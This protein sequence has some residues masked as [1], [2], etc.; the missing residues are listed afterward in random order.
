M[1]NLKKLI[2]VII[3]VMMLV[4]SFATVAAADYADVESTNSYYKAIQVLSGL[5][6]AKGDEAGNFNPK[7]DVKRSEMVAFVCRL[8]GEE[9]IAAGSAS[10]A[11]SDVAVSHWATGYIAWGVN[12]GIIN[13]MGDGTFAPDASVTYQDAV[14]M[15]MRA[16]GYD[17]IA[18]RAEN[19]GYPTGYL[20][21]ASQGKVLQNA[22]YDQTKA[23]TREIIAQLI[24]NALTS[25]LVDVYQYGDTFEDDRYVIYNGKTSSYGLRTLLTYTNEMIKINATVKKTPANTPSLITKNGHMVE[26]SVDNT[27]DEKVTTIEKMIWG[28]E[29][30]SIADFKAYVGE[31]DIADCMGETVE[32]YLGFDEDLNDWVVLAAVTSKSTVTETVSENIVGVVADSSDFIL[33]YKENVTDS[34][35]D[36]EEIDIAGTAEVYVNGV[37]VNTASTIG[38]ATLNTTATG[39]SSIT[40]MKNKADA[41]YTRVF[42]TVYTYK[43]VEEVFAEKGRIKY[44]TPGSLNLDP[45]VRNNDDFFYNIYDADGKAIT[46]A[47]V[48]EGDVLNILVPYGYTLAGNTTPSLDIY[49]TSNTVTGT[50][51]EDAGDSKHYTVAG[52]DYTSTSA[53][54]LGEAGVF[55]ISIDGKIVYTDTSVEINKNFAYISYVEA[56]T[57]MGKSTYTMDLLTLD[58]SFVTYTLATSVRI[59]EGNETTAPAV[60]D[61]ALATDMAY[62]INLCKKSAV[63]DTAAITAASTSAEI[64]KRLITFK[65]DAEGKINEIR[66]MGATAGTDPIAKYASPASY[67]WDATFNEYNGL[68]ADEAKIFVVP[69]AAFKATAITPGVEYAVT[70]DDEQVEVASFTDLGDEDAFTATLYQT[71]ED[72]DD[73]VISVALAPLAPTDNYKTAPMAV[74]K[75]VATALD[76]DEQTVESITFVQS[77]EV[78]TIKAKFGLATGLASGDIFQYK[79]NS[80]GELSEV[81]MVVDMSSAI[82]LDATV[83]AYTVDGVG[84][85]KYGFALGYI[86]DLDS[87]IK[88]A[89][90][91]TDDGT[92]ITGFTGTKTIKL[93][94]DASYTYA[95]VS[96]DDALSIDIAAAAN[97]AQVIDVADIEAADSVAHKLVAVVRINENNRA[98][99][100]VVID[101]G[102][103]AN[104]S[105]T[106][107]LVY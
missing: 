5:G 74:V 19:G 63:S 106:A 25:P 51:D 82:A 29:T 58:G 83:G 8:M 102:T 97:A 3:A 104:T 69:A 36:A 71:K 28:T 34:L 105:F 37:Y 50:V 47:D 10:D 90:G 70:L 27:Y 48:K 65:T 4:S 53:L 2:S 23:A 77:G 44:A 86:A 43:V 76:A 6:I 31:T 68:K 103:A 60:K 84:G 98:T 62:F 7:A 56:D 61:A 11:F 9:D 16:L 55:Y 107:D 15:I 91:I 89:T 66:K 59:L 40:V 22:G 93:V 38:Q 26:L 42:V 35:A 96:E 64:E 81:Q 30:G 78:K 39:A 73:D 52:K 94:E 57:K 33:K 100:I 67:D 85:V 18:Q 14:V 46:L 17:R 80:D 88:L 13:G 92:N 54:T 32:A 49:V 75:K 95:K 41:K 45:E 1:K 87:G 24:F 101:M 21:L 72:N 12:R 79:T 20:K 99:D